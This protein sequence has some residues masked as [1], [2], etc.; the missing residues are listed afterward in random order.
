MDRTA[1]EFPITSGMILRATTDREKWECYI[2]EANEHT[3]YMSIID[4]TGE[5]H[6]VDRHDLYKSMW[7]F[8]P[9]KIE[10]VYPGNKELEQVKTELGPHPDF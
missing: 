8:E 3:G 7:D 5:E 10:F 6:T 1:L 9:T 4:G 2:I